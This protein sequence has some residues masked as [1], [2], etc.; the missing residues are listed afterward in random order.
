MY[1]SWFILAFV[2]NKINGT[3]Y[4]ISENHKTNKLVVKFVKFISEQKQVFNST[5]MFFKKLAKHYYL[6]V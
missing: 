3:K 6:S 4:D 5:N 2:L 1:L